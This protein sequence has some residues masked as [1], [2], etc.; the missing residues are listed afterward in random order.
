[1]RVWS[2]IKFAL[3]PLTSQKLAIFYLILP[4]TMFF[5]LI[6]LSCI[7]GNYFTLLRIPKCFS[8]TWHV[9]FFP[10]SFIFHR[11]SGINTRA[12]LVTIFKLPLI[13]LSILKLENTMSIKLVIF[14]WSLIC[15]FLI[16]IGCQ[17][18]MTLFFPMN[19]CSLI[20]GFIL[21]LNINSISIN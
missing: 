1:M 7:F 17:F 18:T 10:W 14:E 20:N 15:E 11:F 8:S 4:E 13:G 2:W 19:K 5:T 3:K 6:V 16:N 12:L 9:S 21:I